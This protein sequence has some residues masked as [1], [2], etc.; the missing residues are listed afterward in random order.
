MSLWM[1]A[2][3]TGILSVLLLVVKSRFIRVSGY[4]SLLSALVY[5]IGWAST[6]TFRAFCVVSYQVYALLEVGPIRLASG[7]FSALLLTPVATL[8]TGG[9]VALSLAGTI[10]TSHRRSLKE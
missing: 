9:I 3:L 8:A 2:G 5:L 6:P 7:P 4:L 10:M 1:V